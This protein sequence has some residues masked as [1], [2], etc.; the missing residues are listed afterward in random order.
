MT[1]YSFEYAMN[2]R[3]LFYSW[4]DDVEI[5]TAIATGNLHYN[6]NKK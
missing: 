4:F 2:N 1:D 6:G 5:E 3:K